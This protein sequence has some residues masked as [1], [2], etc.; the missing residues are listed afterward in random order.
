MPPATR[1]V[2]SQAVVVALPPACRFGGIRV[3]PGVGFGCRICTSSFCAAISW[4]DAAAG[5]QGAKGLEVLAPTFQT[6]P[7]WL[8]FVPSGL[9]NPALAVRALRPVCRNSGKIT[10]LRA[11][12]FSSR[13]ESPKA[14]C[15]G[16]PLNIPVGVIFL[17]CRVA[18]G[19]FH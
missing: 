1:C 15:F 18:P 7:C 2:S 4:A 6:Q 11:D 3:C 19:C 13:T 17:R 8:F 16:V 5:L 10:A 9:N 14:Y 12:T